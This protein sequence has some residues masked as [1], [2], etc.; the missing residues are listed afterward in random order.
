VL[1]RLQQAVGPDR[2]AAFADLARTVLPEVTRGI[3]SLVQDGNAEMRLHLR[4][5]ELGEVE[6]RVS[7]RDGVVHGQ[8]AVQQPA[9]KQLLDSHVDRLRSALLEH[10]LQLGGF[11]VNVNHQRRPDPEL[12]GDDGSGRVGAPASA[13]AASGTQAAAPV[14]VGG[15]LHGVD[16]T[17]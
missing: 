13:P 3:A 8:V 14:R 15:G 6:L 1:Q 9:I 17:I 7:T 2:A 5:A 11:D 16:Y 10:G 4:P 12:G